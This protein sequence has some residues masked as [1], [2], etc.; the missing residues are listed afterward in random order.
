MTSTIDTKDKNVKTVFEIR[1]NKDNFENA[2]EVKEI[3]KRFSKKFVFQLERGD[4]GYL[5]WQGRMSL[6]KR[7]RTCELKKFLREQNVLNLFNYIAPTTNI[8]HTK[9][10]FYCMKEDTRIE[11]PYKDTDIDQP[12]TKQLQII[13]NS[14]LRPWQQSIIDETKKFC[15]RSIDLIFDPE[16]NNGKS[17]LCDYLE[18]KDNCEA[19]PPYRLMDDLYQWVCNCGGKRLFIFD[20]PRG[21]KKDKLG[22]L[23]SGIE[24]IKNGVAY[25]KRYKNNKIKF[26]RPRIIVFTNVLPCLELMTKDRWKIWTIENN[27][28]KA[29]PIN[30]TLYLDENDLDI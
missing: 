13:L 25:D 17:L 14:E 10:A 18:Y 3:L 29:Y 15:M 23:Y 30:D 7:R 12:I 1:M 9:T 16:G 20:L 21:M 4:S 8:E 5:H 11:G 6:I 28:L 19:V 27:E 2:L 24:V 26:D 22:D